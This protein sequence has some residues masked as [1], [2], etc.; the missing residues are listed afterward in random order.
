MIGLENFFDEARLQHLLVEAQIGHQLLE[1][2]IL[3][4]KLLEPSHLGLPE[5]KGDLFL[6]CNAS[7]SWFLVFL[8]KCKIIKNL[9]FRVDQDSGEQVTA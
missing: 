4:F 2:T 8:R 6:E 3:F 7:A 5:S 9:A 1:F